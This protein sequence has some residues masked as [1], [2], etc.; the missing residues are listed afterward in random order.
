MQ[1][2]KET[3]NV[4]PERG[5]SQAAAESLANEG[6]DYRTVFRTRTGCGL[7]Q[8]ALRFDCGPAALQC[9]WGGDFQPF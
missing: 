8:P 1:R 5:L 9:L 6:W 3:K 4:Y 2:R 7:G